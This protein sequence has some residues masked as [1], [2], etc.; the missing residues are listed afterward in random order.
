MEGNGSS[1]QPVKDPEPSKSSPPEKGT[2]YELPEGEVGPPAP[3]VKDFYEDIKT[4]HEHS[5]LFYENHLCNDELTW[6]LR[7]NEAEGGKLIDFGIITD[8]ELNI[9]V[10]HDYNAGMNDPFGGMLKGA[11]EQAKAFAP[12]ANNAGNP[13]NNIAIK[14]GDTLE[15][16][17]GRMGEGGALAGDTAKKGGALL[18]DVANKGMG[19][20]NNT[21][22]KLTNE[23]VDLSQVINSSFLS[24]Y[25]SV[26]TFTGTVFNFNIPKL[27]T[28]WVHNLPP[29][30]DIKGRFK[31]VTDNIIGDTKTLGDLYGLQLAPNNYRP[32]FVGLNGE[33]QIAFKG[34]FTLFIGNLYKLENLIITNFLY[35]PSVVKAKDHDGPLYATVSYEVEI[36]SYLTRGQ[37]QK[38]V[39]NEGKSKRG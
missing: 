4:H 33:E 17:F 37:L 26:R 28:T 30:A 1:N 35:S 31:Y 5:N 38:I 7:T 39:I 9:G 13:N 32:E 20:L 3:R 16:I 22:K 11:L 6:E 14:V 36:A 10:R 18:A 21:V 27:E 2:I 29:G 15:S 25:D 34:T 24:S 19:F 8:Q 23:S 12:Y